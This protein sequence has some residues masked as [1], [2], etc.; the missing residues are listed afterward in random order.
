M[1]QTTPYAK[2]LERELQVS[3]HRQTNTHTHTRYTDWL[4]LVDGSCVCQVGCVADGCR[5]GC[6]TGI[7]VANETRGQTTDDVSPQLI[8][9]AW[10]QSVS[11]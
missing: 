11:P 2:S 7:V 9:T 1:I 5:G 8:A 4:L 10:D 6:V 3:A